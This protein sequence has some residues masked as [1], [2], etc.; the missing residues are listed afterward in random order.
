MDVY[1]KEALGKL[2]GILRTK[3]FKLNTFD[4]SPLIN[5]TDLS[6]TSN[7]TTITPFETQLI[8][9]VAA[10]PLLKLYPNSTYQ[11]EYFLKISV[12]GRDGST[13]PLPIDESPVLTELAMIDNAEFNLTPNVSLQAPRRFFRIGVAPVS[14]PIKLPN[15]SYQNVITNFHFSC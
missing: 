5:G 8:E 3:N 15:T 9:M 13:F 4:C 1:L 12:F 6:T 10:S 7:P 2:T 11:I 14:T